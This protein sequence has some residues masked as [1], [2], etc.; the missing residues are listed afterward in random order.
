MDGKTIRVYQHGRCCYRCLGFYR[1][2][3]P[4]RATLKR[5]VVSALCGPR[6]V[7]AG[8]SGAD[9]HAVQRNAGGARRG[10]GAALL[11]RQRDAGFGVLRP[12][13]VG[14]VGVRKVAGR[15]IRNTVDA[16][17]AMPAAG[18]AT[19]SIIRRPCRFRL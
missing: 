8:G 11:R 6:V 4:Q 5:V 10:R 16:T 2:T 18:M 9:Q 15:V 1:Q 7:I 19:F 14:V 13:A 17:R 3:S 12:N